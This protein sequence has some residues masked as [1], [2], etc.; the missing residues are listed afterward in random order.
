MA[1][2]MIAVASDWDKNVSPKYDKKDDPQIWATS[3][4]QGRSHGVI[5]GQC[6]QILFVP[7]SFV[8]PR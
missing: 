3:F 4:P 5:R 6:P 7:S 8:I 1:I 2:D